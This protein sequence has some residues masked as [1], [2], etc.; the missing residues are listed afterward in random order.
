MSETGEMAR[1]RTWSLLV[2]LIDRPV[3]TFASIAASPRRRW[4]VPL[5]LVVAAFLVG[6]ALTGQQQVVAATQQM[7]MQL[8]AQ[9]DQIPP[10]QMEQ[11]QAQMAQFTQPAVVLGLAGVTSLLG[12]LLALLLAS[13]V[14]Y[15]SALMSGSDVPFATVWAM[16]PWTWLP[17]ALRDVVR[18]LYVRIT[19]EMALHPGFSGFVAAADMTAN[20]GNPLYLILAQVDLFALWHLGLVYA[21]LR[22]GM[23]LSQG[24]ALALTL[25]YAAISLAVRALPGLLV[26]S[27]IPGAG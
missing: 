26:R 11:V 10:E 22:G 18:G 16:V 27:F 9:A 7:R 8:A 23:R 3:R 6:L 2:G 25:V 13:A 1:E 21:L 20:A 14:I 4:I 19:G 15:F 24:K 17:F 12:L 5:L